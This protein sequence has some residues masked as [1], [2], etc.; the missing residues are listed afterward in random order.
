MGYTSWYK[1][2]FLV[3]R[4]NSTIKGL[5]L[6]EYVVF[7]SGAPGICSMSW[8]ARPPLA[9]MVHFHDYTMGK[10]YATMHVAVIMTHV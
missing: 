4:N 5:Q 2:Y 3:L 10:R 9:L 8:L 7:S 6:L 1:I